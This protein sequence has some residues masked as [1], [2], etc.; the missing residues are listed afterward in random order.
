[1]PLAGGAFLALWNDIARA[2]EPEYDQWHTLEHVPERVS[3]PGFRGA[4]RYANRGREHHRYFTLYEVDSLAA[5][6]TAEYR[7]LLERPTPWS[8]AMRPDFANF[9]RATC[10]VAMS[11][12]Y[13]IGAAIACLCP[14]PGTP[15]EAL[16]AA[17][18]QA[19]A[20]PG[21]NAAHYGRR[22]EA[23]LGVPFRAPPPQSAPQRAFERVALIEALDR[24]A[25]ERAL[26]GVRKRLGW[27]DSPRDFGDDVYELA[28]VFP[29]HDAGEPARHR[30]PGWP[31][32]E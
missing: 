11:R 5:F 8:A 29:G 16:G 15:D 23:A 20:L 12:G 30:R 22:A 19:V 10:A 26:A 31:T 17:L 6:E 25:A 28:F 27:E 9:L 3:A 32:G 14:P 21:V 4:R 7:D 1:M 24:A 2:R 18:A 13:G